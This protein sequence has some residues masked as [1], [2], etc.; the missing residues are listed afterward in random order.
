MRTY[1][2]LAQDQAALR[3]AIMH[4][5]MRTLTPERQAEVIDFTQRSEACLDCYCLFPESSDRESFLRDSY[6]LQSLAWMRIQ[7]LVK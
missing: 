7:R 6:N 5:T 3:D 4:S 1:Q 2:A